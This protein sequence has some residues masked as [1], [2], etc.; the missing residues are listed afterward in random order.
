M[1]EENKEFSIL[2]NID[3]TEEIISESEVTTKVKEPTKADMDKQLRKELKELKSKDNQSIY[4]YLKGL[5]FTKDQSF[6][7]PSLLPKDKG[8]EK[9]VN[10]FTEYFSLFDIYI[11]K[12]SIVDNVDKKEF[13]ELFKFVSKIVHLSYFNSLTIDEVNKEFLKDKGNTRLK[14]ERGFSNYWLVDGKYQL[15][16]YK[17]NG[18]LTDVLGELLFYNVIKITKNKINIAEMSSSIMLIFLS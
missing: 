3:L 14:Y 12:K 13:R 5:M 7:K 17:D 6:D 9:V 11:I 4:N 10:A 1:S 8:G 15:G 16:K 18:D 2:D